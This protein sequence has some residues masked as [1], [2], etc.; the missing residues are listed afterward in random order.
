[1]YYKDVRASRKGWAPQWYGVYRFVL[2]FIVGAAIVVS[3]IGRG[4]VADR[5]GRSSGP[6]ERVRELREYQAEA[7]ETE[8][9]TRRRLLASKDDDEEEDEEEEESDDEE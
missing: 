7:A 9:D 2:T 8:E 3:L 1:M 4:Q 5:I 6:A